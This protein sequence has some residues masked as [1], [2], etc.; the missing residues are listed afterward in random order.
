MFYY[1]LFL[2][3]VSC[4]VPLCLG[5]TTTTRRAVSATVFTKS[6]AGAQN[7]YKRRRLLRR[8]ACAERLFAG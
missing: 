5:S 3:S 4:V 1:S 6:D 2:F 7:R 8:L